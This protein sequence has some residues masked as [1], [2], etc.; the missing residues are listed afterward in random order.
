MGLRTRL[1]LG[2]LAAAL[3]PL[4]LL[5]LAATQAATRAVVG[6]VIELHGQKADNVATFVDTYMSAQVR[7]LNLAIRTFR[8][9]ELSDEGRVGFQRLVYNQFD[10][11]NI[12]SLLGPGGVDVAPSQRVRKESGEQ[13]PVGHESIDEA[14]F[15]AFRERIPL[16]EAQAAGFAV[17]YPYVPPGTDVPVAPVAVLAT[18]PQPVVLAV[19]LSLRNVVRQLDQQA[20]GAV[21]MAILDVRG[22]FVARTAQRLVRSDVF[23]IFLG[24]NSVADVRYRL[25]DGTEVLAA[26]AFVPSTGWLTV[27]AEP[28]DVAEAAGRDIRRRSAYFGVVAAGLAV[29]LGLFFSKRI[30]RPVEDLRDAAFAVGSGALGRTVQ[31]DPIRELGDLGRAFNEMSQHL[32]ANRDEID[33]QR[34]EIEAFN[35]ELQARVEERTRELRDA[36]ARLVESGKLAAVA[37]LGAGLA[38]ELNNPL[39]GV[40]GITQVLRATGSASGSEGLLATLEEQA[41]RCADILRNLQSLTQADFRRESLEILDLDQLLAEVSTLVHGAFEQ[42]RVH[43]HHERASTPTPVRADR[44]RL[45]RALSQLLTSLRSLL[46]EGSVLRVTCHQGP[47]DVRAWFDLLLSEETGVGVGRDDWYVSGMSLWVARRI[48]AEHG[49]RLSEPDPGLPHR[50]ILV[51]P[52][53]DHA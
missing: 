43:I 5:G 53:H 51:L 15:Q 14:R 18:G 21:E 9:E 12:V 16:S 24:G 52:R 20:R 39:A 23:E 37:E 26:F 29:V 4:L 42:R 48:L 2:I 49:G 41:R 1:I 46:P 25:D 45:A 6:R 7:G 40:L 50:F 30:H 44:V 31:P 33:A 22:Q 38:H 34:R 13:P 47:G 35:K 8:L 32:K 27:V 11:V 28:L 36:Q 3:L 17:G 10:D 19:E